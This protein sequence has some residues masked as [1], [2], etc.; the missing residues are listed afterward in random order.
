MCPQKQIILIRKLCLSEL[1]RFKSVFVSTELPK[2][3]GRNFFS[4]ILAWSVCVGPLGN[5]WQEGLW[6]DLKGGCRQHGGERPWLAEGWWCGEESSEVRTRGHGTGWGHPHWPL[7]AWTSNSAT[8]TLS[9]TN[10]KPNS[11][12]FLEKKTFFL[13]HSRLLLATAS[14]WPLISDHRELAL[15]LLSLSWMVAEPFHVS[16]ANL[17]FVYS[18]RT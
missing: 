18:S 4:R 2:S 12:V 16:L 5:W 6:S 15:I 9:S 10:P 11:P 3:S 17:E 7:W 13:T 1:V 14:S 8:T